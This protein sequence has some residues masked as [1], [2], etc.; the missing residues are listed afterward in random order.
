M[1]AHVIGF[2]RLKYEYSTCP[3]FGIIYDEVCDAP[4]PRCPLT[5][6]QP[7]ENLHASHRETHTGIKMAS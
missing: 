7:A 3:D 4:N 5:T 1:S 2:D 6:R